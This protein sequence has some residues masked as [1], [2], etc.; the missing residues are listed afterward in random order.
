[1]DKFEKYGTSAHISGRINSESLPGFNSPY[2]LFHWRGLTRSDPEFM[3]PEMWAQ[4]NTFP[5]PEPT[6][7][8]CGHM[9]SMLVCWINTVPIKII[10]KVLNF[11]S[12]ILS[13]I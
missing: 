6:F 10:S 3:R 9:W 13:K 7:I 2:M 11:L 5:D 4:G 12:K 1:M 8:C